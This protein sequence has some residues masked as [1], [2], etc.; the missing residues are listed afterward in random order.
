[1]ELMAGL[2]PCSGINVQFQVFESM[3][4]KKILKMIEKQ[5]I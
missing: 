1:M 2:F 3:W 4:I 5:K